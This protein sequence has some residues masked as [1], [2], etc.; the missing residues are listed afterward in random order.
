[1]LGCC[2]GAFNRGIGPPVVWLVGA[3]RAPFV[4]RTFPLSTGETRGCCHRRVYGMLDEWIRPLFQ[5]CPRCQTV[6]PEVGC[7]C[8]ALLHRS[9]YFDLVL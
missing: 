5:H 7:W 3:V 1:M 9:V 6:G 4:L 2:L 8:V